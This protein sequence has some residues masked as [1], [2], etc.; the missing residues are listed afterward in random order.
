MQINRY[1][2]SG[3]VQRGAP[4][5]NDQFIYKDYIVNIYSNSPGEVYYTFDK[6]SVPV[7]VP[8]PSHVKEK[9][10]E[11]ENNLKISP[12][13]KYVFAVAIIGVTLIEDAI[14]GGIGIFND[15]PSIS[16]GFSLLTGN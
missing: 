8:V 4:L 6:I 10:K 7:S 15:I 1:T 14:S 16:F 5:G 9:T 3:L 12:A 13:L 2:K 11:T